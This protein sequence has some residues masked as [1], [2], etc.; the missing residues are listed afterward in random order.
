MEWVKLGDVVEFV[1]SG[2]WG[3]EVTDLTKTA[4]PV[5]R[6]TN[7]NNDGT[8]DYK[9]IVY[10]D[11]D[12]EKKQDKLIKKGDILIE[13][14]GGSPNQP[15]G[16]VVYFEAEDSKF[17]NNNFTSILRLN[18]D[19]HSKYIFYLFRYLYKIGVVNKFQNKTT[20]IINL[21]LK[22][23][24]QQTNILIYKDK[25]EQ[26][27]CS[28]SLDLIFDIITTRKA[29]IAALD[30]LVQS[31]FYDMFGEN[32]KYRKN[33]PLTP[34]NKIG[35]VRS[36][37]RVFKADYVEDGVPFYRGK[38]ITELS[39]NKNIEIELFISKDKYKELREISGVPSVGDLM[40]TSVGTI[41]NIWIVNNKESFYFKDGNILWFLPDK[42]ICNSEYLKF[43]IE[44][45][46]KSK[47]KSL[48]SGT[49]YKALTISNL[50]NLE[51]PIPPLELQEQFAAK[52]EEIEAQKAKLQTSLEEME[53]LF[54]A[55]MQEAFNGNLG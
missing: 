42:N 4:S 40:I 39:K 22:D 10:R 32:N 41:G 8:I 54:D 34:L 50:E 17:F 14:S 55:L 20:G 37:R 30:E 36:S 19:Y 21:K 31:V 12:L 2:E 18:S 33:F 27:V 6:T 9:D 43:S 24:L 51:I 3:K 52:V 48:T 45:A 35:I 25:E 53:I 16:R 5:I 44:L 7:F 49:S 47:L 13:K 38:E 46:I 1:L 23:Y 26:K 15:V 11:I 28:E 29:Q